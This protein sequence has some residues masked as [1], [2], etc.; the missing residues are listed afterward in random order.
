MKN[1]V[2]QSVHT[3]LKL[4]QLRWAGHVIR[5]PGELLQKKIFYGKFQDEK[6]S[7][8]GQKKC[9]KDN[10]KA[11]LKDFNIPNDTWEQ[12]AHDRTKWRCLNKKVTAQK[13]NINS[14]T[15]TRQQKTPKDY[16]KDFLP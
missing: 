2:M 4:A 16:P 9:N 1:A 15:K 13:R 10:L 3:L 7:Q 6:R 12:S 5:M 8:G 14:V 11:L